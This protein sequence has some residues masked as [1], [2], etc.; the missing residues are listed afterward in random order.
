[1]SPAERAERLAWALVQLDSGE[2]AQAVAALEALRDQHMPDEPGSEA[3][4]AEDSLLRARTLLALARAYPRQGRSAD[5]VRAGGE[6][7]FWFEQLGDCPQSCDAHT[8]LAL[9]Y[10]QSGVGREALEQA[11]AA[12]DIARALG[13]E[14][15][16]AW[17]L[18]RVG[19]AHSALGNPMQGRAITQEAKTIAQR[20]QIHEL[21]FAALNNQAY[22]T[23][24]ELDALRLEGNL[25]DAA[26]TQAMA[27]SLSQQALE[28][29]R[30]SANPYREAMALSHLNESLL[31][32]QEWLRA[33]QHIAEL[34]Q[35]TQRYGL[36]TLAVYAQLQRAQLAAGQGQ[37]QSAIELTDQLLRQSG[38]SLL[39]RQRKAALQLLYECHKAWGDMARS[40]AYLEELVRLERRA[41]R[42]A[43][44]VQTQLLM[45]REEV[46]QAVRQ[47]ERAQAESSR[48]RELNMQ[49]EREHL[50]LQ[51]L[52]QDTD[53]AARQDALTGLANRRHAEEVLAQLNQQAALLQQPLALAMLD[54]D[55]FKRVNDEHGHATGDAVLRALAHL[56]QQQLRDADL[57]ARWGGEEFLVA[58]STSQ[59]DV[60]LGVL[61]RLRSAVASEDWSRLGA[62]QAVTVSIGLAIAKVSAEGWEAQ[63]ARAD[64]ALYAAKAQG[65]NRIVQ[66]D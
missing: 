23:L 13:D 57:L 61:E 16:E 46:Q 55:H 51:H 42:D 19:N 1:V 7:L 35:L 3:L 15:R 39:P 24:D 58:F 26:L 43:Q 5:A 59:A 18:L 38:R 60:A 21:N 64:Q 36:P 8:A 22:F 4:S 2:H 27:E 20:L 47:A 40:L 37:W 31:Y 54:L 32:G 10:A 11:M 29:A 6:A 56:M 50:A 33:E 9:A 12:L 65:R 62:E 34:E 28:L 53:R 25:T 44:R 66:A 52:L 30:E 17:A 48:Q 41:N 49:L 45:I 14:A 63:L